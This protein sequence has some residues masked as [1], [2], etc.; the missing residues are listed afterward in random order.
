MG[1]ICAGNAENGVQ[2]DGCAGREGRTRIVAESRL[3]RMAADTAEAE[4]ALPAIDREAPFPFFSIAV[5][6]LDPR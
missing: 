2:V 6:A 5:S 4:K 3:P 1:R